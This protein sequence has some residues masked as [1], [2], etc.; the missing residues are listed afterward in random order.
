M[1]SSRIDL[2]RGLAAARAGRKGEA[3]AAFR[4]VLIQE[5]TNEIALLWL[6][7]LSDNPRASLA[8]IARAL[9]AHPGSER[10]RSALR[11][12]RQRLVAQASVS[13]SP[14]AISVQAARSEYRAV[15]APV[16]PSRSLLRAVHRQ[17]L[18][19]GLLALLLGYGTLWL[20]GGLPRALLAM[21]SPSPTWTPTPTF[22]PTS[23]PTATWTPTPTA[24]LTPPP[25]PTP[26]PTPT[27]TPTPTMTPR[28]TA[29]RRPPTAT[30]PT[31]VHE[32]RWIDVDLTRQVLTAY[33]GNT[34]VRVI[35]VSTGLPR[36]PTPTGQFRIWAKLRYDDMRGPDY[37]LPN[38]PY[39]MYFYGGY[40]LHGTYW[41]TN[42][43]RPMSHG[44]VNLPT[45][46]A[47]WLFN[48]A[49]V[50]TLVNIH[51]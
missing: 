45:P 4:A 33:E 10:A 51:Y 48:W 5:P 2:Q 40:S 24:T 22:I 34:P 3:R 28:P 21:F 27:S 26:T 16:I 19:L 29:T 11:W 13:P 8:Y 46:E 49:E 6:A 47:E 35:V 38:V 7:Y 36:T 1:R 9:E 25:T 41:H 37:Y 23:T 20:D 31:P 18:I 15:P 42:F 39:V 44:C 32:N 17:W 50:G 12:A 30:L 43:G 14:P